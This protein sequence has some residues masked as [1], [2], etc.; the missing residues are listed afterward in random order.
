MTNRFNNNNKQPS[1]SIY[2]SSSVNK[3]EQ[4]IQNILLKQSLVQPHQQ[5][6]SMRVLS[7]SNTPFDRALN[8]RLSQRIISA[9]KPFSNYENNNN[10][11]NNNNSN[12]FKPL[13]N[14]SN[15]QALLQ[16][17]QKNQMAAAAA[18]AAAV[19]FSFCYQYIKIFYNY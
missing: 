11:N 3:Q 16:Q 18:A 12:A 4:N 6:H 7:N 1:S 8:E 14:N 13:N 17:N 19:S 9:T 5:R 10:N 2:T 15:N